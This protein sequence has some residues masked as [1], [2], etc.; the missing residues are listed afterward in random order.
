MT[1]PLFVE[2]ALNYCL[3]SEA[4]SDASPKESIFL[5]ALVLW[6]YLNINVVHMC[7][8]I[9]IYIYIYMHVCAYIHTHTHT[10]IFVFNKLNS[11]IILDLQIHILHSVSSKC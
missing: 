10:H 4:P 5:R 8:C 9:Y 1:L 6:V 3:T 11:G 2:R 7:A